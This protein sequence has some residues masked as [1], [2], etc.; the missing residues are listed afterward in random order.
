MPSKTEIR[1]YQLLKELG[2]VVDATS[3]DRFLQGFSGGVSYS[4]DK[5]EKVLK[6]LRDEAERMTTTSYSLWKGGERAG[7]M[8]AIKKI[9]KALQDEPKSKACPNC[10]GQR[11]IFVY[12]P[13]VWGGGYTKPCP[14]CK[15]APQ[16]TFRI[17]QVWLTTHVHISNRWTG[18]MAG[19][20][21]P[22]E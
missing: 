10:S 1:L 8:L 4:R 22:T 5:I 6:E 15:P 9:D 12:D 19:F 20:A 14:S 3:E 17:G 18:L 7:L 21:P 11:C 2:D 16:P 13:D